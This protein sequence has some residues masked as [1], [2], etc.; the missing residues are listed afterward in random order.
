MLLVPC[1][2]LALVLKTRRQPGQV[3]H[4]Y[5]RDRDHFS[6]LRVALRVCSYIAEPLFYAALLLANR[7]DLRLRE[8]VSYDD[9]DFQNEVQHG[10]KTRLIGPWFLIGV[11]KVDMG[12]ER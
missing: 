10:C 11:V 6:Y 2:Q 12:E 1:T 4:S 8:K 9:D 5:A 7:L 3:S